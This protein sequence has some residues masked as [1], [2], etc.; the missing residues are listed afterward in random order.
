MAED[1]AMSVTVQNRRNRLRSAVAAV[2]TVLILVP[3]GILF[4]TVWNRTADDRAMTQAEVHGVE[5]LNKL[6]P[7][8]PVLA[9][10]QSA[11]LAGNNAPPQALDGLVAGIAEVD[12]RLGAEL[13]TRQRWSGL[14]DKLDELPS[15]TGG[16]LAVYQ[17]H[18]EAA[19][20]LLALLDAV[21]D[22]SQLVRDPDNDVA[23][24]QQV[25]AAD[26][27]ETVTQAGRMS[28]LS[29]IVQ[30]APAAQRPL[31][32]AE[33]GAAIKS[34]D[35]T[36]GRLTDNLQSAVDDTGSTSLSS[37][38]LQPVDGFRRNVEGITQG[39]NPAGKPDPTAIATA[40]G[41]TGQV[42]STL[43]GVLVKEMNAQLQDRLDRLDTDQLRAMIAAA[44]AV[45][46]V[47]LAIILPLL[48]FRRSARAADNGSGRTGDRTPTDNEY[49]NSHLDQLPPFGNEV[50]PTR[51]ERSGALR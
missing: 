35:T 9:E 23:N 29:L 4:A 7:L 15:V 8:V 37:G 12:G 38:L 45:V 48:L 43:N 40:R 19:D 28:D 47:L 36:V 32:G 16:A 24:L 14:R 5:Y 21:R 42:V 25:L 27:P 39:A 34:V 11:A 20:L 22:N 33:Y 44:A 17:A 6:A 2:L 41:Q 13:G 18:V 26:L 46:L 1:K 31:L 51:R 10:G 30:S 3:L 49:G 50:S